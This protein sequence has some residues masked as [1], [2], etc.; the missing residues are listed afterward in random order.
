MAVPPGSSMRALRVGS[1]RGPTLRTALRGARSER[2]KRATGFARIESLG[3]RDHRTPTRG[4]PAP[5]PRTRLAP[6]SRHPAET[7]SSGLAP[8]NRALNIVRDIRSRKCPYL[9]GLHQSAAGAMWTNK[10]RSRRHLP[11]LSTACGDVHFK[12]S[13]PTYPAIRIPGPPRCTG[14][15][16]RP[17]SARRGSRPRSRRTTPP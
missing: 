11:L 16:A 4:V 12:L 7:G 8:R 6:T 17:R 15:S 13:T 3:R 14:S 9:F 10:L 2:A 1:G 5:P